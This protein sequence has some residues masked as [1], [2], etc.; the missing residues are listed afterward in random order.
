MISL[1][2]KISNI[3]VANPL[4]LSCIMRQT[5]G[6]FTS[7]IFRLIKPTHILKYVYMHAVIS[8]YHNIINI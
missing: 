2:L 4:D 3:K 1:A 6:Q 8:Q 7:R 5:S